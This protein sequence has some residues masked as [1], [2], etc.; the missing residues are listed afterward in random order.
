MVPSYG[1]AGEAAKPRELRLREAAFQVA[2]KVPPDAPGLRPNRLE[3]RPKSYWSSPFRGFNALTHLRQPLNPLK[4][5]PPDAHGP[6][7]DSLGANGVLC[8]GEPEKQLLHAS[9]LLL[10]E[11][12]ISALAHGKGRP[13]GGRSARESG[14][15][16]RETRV[17]ARS[18]FAVRTRTRQNFA[19]KIFGIGRA[20]FPDLG[21]RGGP[22]LRGRF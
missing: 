16:L 8:L 9:D 2:G 13:R 11:R 3:S 14:R 18:R 12:L 10:R 6:R 22:P 20:A 17:R 4:A 5:M 7:L 21:G 1:P 19:A 15:L